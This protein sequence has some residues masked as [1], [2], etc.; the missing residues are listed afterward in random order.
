LRRAIESGKA[1]GSGGS[2]GSNGVENHFHGS[3]EEATELEYLRNI[4]FEYMMGRQPATLSKVV[5]AIVKFT[6]EQTRKIAEKEEQRQSL[7]GFT[8]AHKLVYHAL[9]IPIQARY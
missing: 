3:L 8:E 1:S 2:S 4:M 7:V 5:A 6:P 9:I